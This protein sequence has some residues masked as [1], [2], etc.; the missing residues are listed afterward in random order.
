MRAALK[1]TLF[2]LGAAAIAAVAVAALVRTSGEAPAQARGSAVA[3]GADLGQGPSGRSA[4]TTW[5]LA[6][7]PSDRGLA[8]GWQRGVFRGREV[9]VPDVVDAR[10]IKGAAGWRNYEGSVAWYRTTFPAPSAGTYALS[11]ASANFRASVY[12]DGRRVATH[13]GSY[14]PFEAR[15]ALAAGAH[16]VVVRVDWRDPTRQV[17]E[18]FHRTWF[19]WGGLDGAVS[20]REVGE[21]ELSEPSIAVSLSPDAPGAARASVQVTTLVSNHGPARTIAPTGAL[22]RE[23]VRIPF[24]FQPR[25]FA[26]GETATMSAR[27]DVAHPALWA[28]KHPDLYELELYAAPEPPAGYDKREAPAFDARVGLRELSRRGGLLY[29][30]GARL[31]LHGASLQEDARGHGDALTPSED[32]QLVSELESVGANVVRSQHPLDP[33]LVERLDAAG[34]FVWQGIGPV[35]GAG[36][37]HETTPALVRAALAQS[38]TAVRELRLHPSIL[39]WNLVD[40][41]AENAHSPAEVGYVQTLASW[42]HRNDPGRLV[43]IEVWGTHPPAVAGPIYAGVDAVAETDYTGWYDDAAASAARQ[44]TLM[45]ARLQTMERTFAGKV[46]VIS[47]FGAESNALNASGSPGGYSFQSSLL[48]RHISVYEHDP[49][50][51]GM[52]VWNLRDYPLIPSY[53]GGSIVNELPHLRLVEGMLEKGLFTYAGAAKPAAGAVARL[54]RSMPST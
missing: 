31:L 49:R 5:T 14:L 24:E 32:D 46:L 28:P 35:E 45:R 44:R 52:L 38:M 43:A 53:R 21:A 2:A 39:A 17:G 40:E 19:N 12:V 8:R 36:N 51:T 15:A 37:W 41:V 6:L 48:E 13:E 4:L 50:L 3:R 42:L 20:V 11:F 30:N 47:E 22:V 27:V 18:G 7:D 34:I 10:D 1:R 25:A 33:A 23:G 29:L 9:S 16:T 54:F 26:A